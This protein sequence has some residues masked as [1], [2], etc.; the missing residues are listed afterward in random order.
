MIL[1]LESTALAD[2]LSRTD[3]VDFDHQEVGAL[4]LRLA[5]RS[6]SNLELIQNSYEFVRD[7]IH[8]SADI[9]GATVT[10]TASQVLA[11]GEG[12]CY[13]K[14]HLLAALLR[15]NA[16]PAGFCYQLLRASSA[17]DAPLV[18]HG[19]NAVFIADLRKWIR[20]DARGNKCGIDAQFSP[21][22]EQ[23]AYR[24]DPEF[25]EIDFPIVFAAP[26]ERVVAALTA[27]ETL[28][29]LWED[30]P[31]YPAKM[32]W[33]RALSVEQA[34]AVRLG[35]NPV[36]YCGHHCDFCFL[37]QWCG[38]C[39]SSYNHC[40]YATLGEGNVCPNVRCATERNLTGCYE[41]PDVPDCRKGYYERGDEYI[42]KASALFCQK[43]GEAAY[44]N[45]LALA[46]D[47]GVNYPETFDSSGSV[48]NA[49]AILE[50][51]HSPPA[52][53]EQGQGAKQAEACP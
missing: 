39:R 27:H 49:L 51:F 44:A 1:K 3:I 7:A 21:A 25:G 22:R 50:K 11:A 34:A 37:R 38:G 41:C 12:L 18:V 47:N 9:R 43:Y 45:A 6:S 29:E 48:D 32:D 14:S 40:S 30:L 42:A 24:V 10:C 17:P 19:L 36:G 23:L 15:S 8:H 28:A 20:L 16:I 46:I 4:A 5:E 35:L 31:G 53:E 33:C 52:A 26:D 2:Y 13:A